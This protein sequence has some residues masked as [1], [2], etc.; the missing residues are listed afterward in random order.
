MSASRLNRQARRCPHG[1]SCDDVLR[2]AKRFFG[3]GVFY[4]ARFG[5]L[6]CTERPSGW[7]KD[8]ESAVYYKKADGRWHAV[9]KE[10]LSMAGTAK[11]RDMAQLTPKDKR[12]L[13]TEAEEQARLFS[14]AAMASGRYPELRLLFHIPNGGGR[15]KAEA[16]RFKREGVK[17]G[18]PDLCLPA[19]RGKYHGL[20]IELKRRGGGRISPEQKVWVDELLGQGY[21]A[22]IA[23]GWEDASEKL[24][25]YLDLAG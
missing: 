7:A 23:Y 12:L 4:I 22:V 10:D 3:D 19:A 20:F 5:D 2:R 13:P 8:P 15:S 6:Y 25:Q 11:T 21:L 17:A 16:G 24:R 9:E 1:R 14:W 18:V